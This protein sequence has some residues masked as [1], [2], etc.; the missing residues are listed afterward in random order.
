MSANEG[1]TSKKKTSK[2]KVIRPKKKTTPKKDETTIRPGSLEETITTV[3]ETEEIVPKKRTIDDVKAEVK[4]ATGSEPDDATAQA[5][6][7]A[8]TGADDSPFPGEDKANT[9]IVLAKPKPKAKIDE[10]PN[11]EELDAVSDL[12]A[13]SDSNSDQSFEDLP[14]PGQETHIFI[15]PTDLLQLNTNATEQLLINKDLQILNARS[16]VINGH[17][18]LAENAKALAEA[19]MEIV[20]R[21]Q[22]ILE[23][24]KKDVARAKGD[25]Q[26]KSRNYMAAIKSKYKIPQG[27]WAF[28]PETGEVKI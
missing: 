23:Y 17:M 7:D 18:K 12:T 1:A 4:A 22:K 15:D 25:A 8:E 14:Y 9:N 26:E 10:K 11:K 21:D 19:N 28:D 13:E 2:N 16:E 6:L 20:I 5:I 3:A 24:M 27:K